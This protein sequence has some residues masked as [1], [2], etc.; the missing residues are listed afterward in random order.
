MRLGILN[1]Q[2]FQ[3][4]KILGQ[5]VI[6]DRE[7]RGRGF[8]QIFWFR[9]EGK[10]LWLHLTAPFWHDRAGVIFPGKLLCG[11]ED[12]FV[13]CAAAEIP[14]QSGQD[15]LL[16]RMR[17]A[18]QTRKQAHHKAR[19]AISALGAMMIQQCL[20]D[21]V[22][23]FRTAQTF[24]GDEVF[25]M[26]FYRGI[27]AGGDGLIGD[28][29]FM[30]AGYHHRAGTTIPFVTATFCA[31]EMKLPGDK[32]QGGNPRSDVHLLKAAIQVKADPVIAVGAAVFLLLL[33]N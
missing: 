11:I 16:I 29:A 6:I 20:L 27:E 17:N 25:A 12:G 31:I 30:R 22:Q 4:L 13:T 21:G 5:Q 26:Q 2:I 10:E 7:L 24:Y 19:S 8:L 18:R 15:A 32:F 14:L 3:L 23:I 28:A 1:Q 9:I 33:H